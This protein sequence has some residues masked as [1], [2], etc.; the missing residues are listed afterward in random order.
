MS[1]AL[2]LALLGVTLTLPGVQALLCQLLRHN[3]VFNVSA[4]P[5]QWT[6]E[7]EQC[8]S[9]EGCQDTLMIIENGPQAMVVI[10]KGCTKG[11]DHEAR[12]TLHRTG[13]GLSVVSYTHVCREADLCNDLSNSAPVWAPP[14][15]TAPG[16]LRCP[17]C[18]STD[19]CAGDVTEAC[20]EGSTHCYNGVLRL[21]GGKIFTRL[22]VQGCMSQP[23]CNLL[24][25]T[26]D[27]GP[28]ELRESCNVK[29]FPICDYG[30]NIVTSSSLTHEPV[31]WDPELVQLCD[32]GQE[33]QETLLLIDAGDNS[34]LL[35][36]KGC[37]RAGAQDS[38]ATSIHA[39]PTGVLMASYTR[40]CSSNFCNGAN[41]SSVL[42]KSL[43]RPAAPAPGGLQ[44][45]SCVNIFGSCSQNSPRITCPNSTAHCYDGRIS[46]KGGGVTTTVG[47][48]GCVAQSSTSLLSHTRNIGVFSVHEN[49]KDNDNYNRNPLL[50][51]GAALTASLAQVLGLGPA[52]AL[53]YGGLCVSR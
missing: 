37:S 46:V 45:P 2:L 16:P 24:N 3:S 30:T 49:K 4:L 34:A 10:S 6:A 12:V 29:D 26:R 44:C 20:P 21:V 28:I 38:Q 33:C 53:W 13:P 35:W 23:G 1:S 22:Q 50:Q 39:G 27:I 48:Q 32:A 18:L 25:G 40:F 19:S 36:S 51:S 17:A 11:E 14:L 31:Y 47:I 52:L 41:S 43:P 42:L 7:Q 15:Q 9:G 8:G 5:V